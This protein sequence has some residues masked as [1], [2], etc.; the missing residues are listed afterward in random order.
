MEKHRHILWTVSYMWGKFSYYKSAHRP[1]LACENREHPDNFQNESVSSA[2]N[3]MLKYILFLAKVK[4]KEGLFMEGPKREA[5]LW[6]YTQEHF[7]VIRKETVSPF[8]KFEIIHFLLC[9][10]L[11]LLTNKLCR[12]WSF[13]INLWID[14]RTYQSKESCCQHDKCLA[15]T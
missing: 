14:S 2:V 10:L 5:T 1:I 11:D 15:I 3:W 8:V 7:V 9:L 12:T 6:D 13:M 4:R